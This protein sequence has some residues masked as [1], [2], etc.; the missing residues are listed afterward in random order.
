MRRSSS[1]SHRRDLTYGFGLFR[2]DNSMVFQ[3]QVVPGHRNDILWQFDRPGVYTIRSTEYSGPAGIGDGR[4]GRRRGV[5]DRSPPHDSTPSYDRGI[6]MSFSQTLSHGAQG[7][8][9]PD[10][11]TPMQKMTLRFVVVGLVYYGFAVVEG[12]IMRMYQ[13]TPL[14]RRR[15]GISSSPS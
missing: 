1:M 13:V 15:A 4:K 3:M 11:L 6:H 8:F 5:C 2:P 12:M 7:L 14:P 10:T 9:R